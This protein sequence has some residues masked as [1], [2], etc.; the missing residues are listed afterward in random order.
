MEE[1]MDKI[2]YGLPTLLLALAVVAATM[3]AENLA[4]IFAVLLLL[5][6][7]FGKV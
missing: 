7:M 1:I 5:S 2:A 4:G 6:L 3:G